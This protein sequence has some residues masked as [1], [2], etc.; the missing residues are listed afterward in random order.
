M[1]E[2]RE[3]WLVPSL[4]G[5]VLRLGEIKFTVLM[6]IAGERAEVGIEFKLVLLQSPRLSSVH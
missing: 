6:F 5:Q 4:Q 2:V 1:R 3:A